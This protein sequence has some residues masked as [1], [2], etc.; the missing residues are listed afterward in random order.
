MT[1]EKERYFTV[2]DNKGVSVEYEI[3]FTFDSDETKKSYIV[4]TDNNEDEDGSVITYAATYEKDGEK[5]NL[6]DIETEKE[7]DLIETLL[8]QIEEKSSN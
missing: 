7:W 8:A 3:L 1:N 6:S 5:L 4:F 2:T